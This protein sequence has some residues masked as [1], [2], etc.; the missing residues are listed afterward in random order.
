ML[1]MLTTEWVRSRAA[2]ELAVDRVAALL[3]SVPDPGA[4]AVGEWNVGE[5]AVHLSQVWLAVP[6]LARADL[7]ELYRVVPRLA[8]IA[9]DSLVR[10]IW[11]L[12]EAT[13][14]GVRS[15]PERN[16]AVLADRIEAEAARYLADAADRDPDEPRPWLVEGVLVPRRTLTC[17]L[18]NETVMHGADIARAAGLPWPVDPADAAMLL[19]GFVVPVIRALHPTA[20]VD[21]AR[22]AGVTATY[23]VRIRGHA[24]Y[25]FVFDRGELRVE[26]P[27]PRPVDCH[28]S[29]DPVALL[30]LVW[31]RRNQWRDIA[32][33]RLVAW[34]RRPWLGPRLRGLMRN[35]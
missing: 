20:M 24:S 23:D 11:D 12:A 30:H 10:D 3:R 31:G 19:T 17:H 28:L 8:G 14:L 32:R 34:G 2:L 4:P 18:L 22:A 1:G 5:L 27:A 7:S 21:Q 16:P 6:G 29:A 15:E 26:D 35:P 9:G 33:G 25:H 13:Q